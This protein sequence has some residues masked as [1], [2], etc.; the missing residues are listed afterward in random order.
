MMLDYITKIRANISIY[1]T[2]KTSNI[3][4]GA[5]RSVYMGRSMNFEDLREYIPGDNIRDIDW[6]ASSRSRNLLVKRYIAEKKHNIMLVFD[7]GKKM[8]G[9]TRL[10]ECK[11]DTALFVGGTIAYI[12]FRNGDNVGALYNSDGKI[13]FHQLRTGLYNVEKILAAYNSDATI[14]KKNSISKTLDYI[15]NNFKRKMIIFIISDNSGAYEIEDSALKKLIARHDVLFVNIGDAEITGAK[16][17][18]LDAGKYI[19]SFISNNKTLMRKEREKREEVR[20]AVEKK[21][22]RCGISEVEIDGKEEIVSKVTELLEKH[23]YANVH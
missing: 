21:F 13:K 4:D 18:D 1:T 15:I 3:L 12:A 8:S 5:Y 2:K 22:V 11:K 7:T 19:P 9:D 23:R 6:K 17:F 10:E 14:G 16:S 20:A